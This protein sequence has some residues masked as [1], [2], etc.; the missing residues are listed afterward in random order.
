MSVI[1]AAPIVLIVTLLRPL[2]IIRFGTMP[3]GRIGHFAGDIEAY[4]CLREREHATRRTVDIIG[5]PQPA[6]NTQLELMWE[7]K[8]RVTPGA[9]LW[10][11]LDEACLFWT[12][13]ERHHVKLYGRRKD[14]VIFPY[15]KIQLQF[16]ESERQQGIGLLR[17]LGIPDGAS[18][19]CIHNR[20]SAYLDNAGKGRFPQHDYRNFSIDSMGLASEELAQ[21]GHYVLRMGSLVA[22]KFTINNNPKIIDYAS[23]P[24]RSDF[25]DIYLLANCAAY[26]G[27]DSGVFA[28]PFVFRKPMHHVNYSSTQIDFLLDQFITD[29]VIV[30]RLW[31]KEKQR[32]LSM[33]EIFEI[34]LADASET[35]LFEK[36]GLEVVNNTAEEIREFA[37]EIDERLRG[38]WHPTRDDRILQEAFWENFLKYSPNKR[39]EKISGRIGAAFLRKHA[40]LLN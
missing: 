30:K 23:S 7:R 29:P 34:D 13:G 14:Y 39:A 16:S 15:I 32:F 3:S 28:I 27:G 18:W 31:H 35:F 21:R 40:D 33:R 2:V 22:E 17:Q 1:S 26:F 11:V 20:D 19:I 4:L 8:I 24:F 36:N 10:K 9:T 38:Q 12:R 37:I 5:C 25:A 6:C